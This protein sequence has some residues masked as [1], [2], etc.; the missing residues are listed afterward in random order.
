MILYEG[1]FELKFDYAPKSSRE[2]E[3][4]SFY[5]YFNDVEVLKIRPSLHGVTK[6]VVTVNGREGPNVLEFVDNGKIKH[7]GVAIDNVGI[8]EWRTNELCRIEEIEAVGAGYPVTFSSILNEQHWSYQLNGGRKG[9]YYTW[10]P[11]HNK[12][13]GNWIQVSATE[14]K[15]WNSVIIQGRGDGHKHWV[16]SFKV[17]YTLDG[18]TWMDY[19]NGK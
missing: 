5:V 2:P 11:L 8:Y 14:P 17:S 4:S 3:E 15:L 12:E 9:V 10:C 7:N 16:T 1:K 18:K 6:I 13:I 19:E